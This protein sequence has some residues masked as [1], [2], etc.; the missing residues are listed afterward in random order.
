[1]ATNCDLKASGIYKIKL[2]EN[3]GVELY[4]PIIS[5]LDKANIIQNAVLTFEV[6]SYQKP[7]W[8]REL[9]NSANFVNNFSDTLSFLMSDFDNQELLILKNSRFGFWAELYMNNGY[10]IVLHTPLF[11]EKS[12]S[13]N[14]NKNSWLVTL[15]YR[16]PTFENFKYIQTPL[17]PDPD[18]DNINGW[19]SVNLSVNSY[20]KISDSSFS[21]AGD[22]LAINGTG[23]KVDDQITNFIKESTFDGLK[24]TFTVTG[25]AP[26]PISLSKLAYK[27]ERFPQS[28]KYWWSTLNNANNSSILGL[29][30]NAN[31]IFWT[32]SKAT[33]VY[34][35][36]RNM[37]EG[38]NPNNGTFNF[39]L[40]GLDL[41]SSNKLLNTGI[42]D[43]G[44]NLQNNVVN[45]ND[46]I[47]LKTI[48]ATGSNDVGRGVVDVIAFI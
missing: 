31:E 23:L 48:I 30:S 10:I 28:R 26:M 27:Y 4:Y 6:D 3:R 37:D 44:I 21:L 12:T 14:S 32:D 41:I 40:N 11:F 46:E 2:Y 38:S 17:T 33:I 18:M 8:E 22:F 19:Y 39:S 34:L 9:N 43:C 15:N 7:T 36:N 45:F 42:V 29:N 35:A 5:D 13:Q 16:V 20:T 47:K 25:S 24:T 1:M